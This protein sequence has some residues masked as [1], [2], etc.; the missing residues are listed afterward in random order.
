MN[1]R[2]RARSSVSARTRAVGPV[3]ERITRSRVMEREAFPGPQDRGDLA[4]E[5]PQRRA[6]EEIA[7]DTDAATSRVYDLLHPAEQGVR[8]AGF[9]PPAEQD[10]YGSRMHELDELGL[11]SGIARFHD[12]GAEV[13]GRSA[14]V[15]DLLGSP[16]PGLFT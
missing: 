11:G 2:R 7:S 15:T 12:I 3:N 16:S 8:R 14:G 1:S 4:C 5:W 13:G 9:L 10:G 6:L